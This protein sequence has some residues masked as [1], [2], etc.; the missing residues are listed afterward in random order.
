MKRFLI[1]LFVAAFTIYAIGTLFMLGRY[2]FNTTLNGKDVSLKTPQAVAEGLMTGVQA[3]TLTFELP[4][5]Q[6]KS[7]TFRELGVFSPEAVAEANR[8]L[9][10]WAWPLSLFEKTEYVYEETLKY[11]ERLFNQTIENLAFVK[12]GTVAPT[13]AHVED[14]G[15]GEFV[16]VK[17]KLGNQINV[18]ALKNAVLDALRS[19]DTS[20]DVYE[21]GCYQEAAVKA[22]G[23]DLEALKAEAQKRHDLYEEEQARIR[24]EEAERQRVE[25]LAQDREDFRSMKITLDF[26]ANT[27][28]TL[29]PTELDMMSKVENNK[30]VVDEQAVW[31]YVQDLARIYDTHGKSRV[32][33]T[34][35]GSSVM[36][37]PVNDGKCTLDGWEMNQSEA[38]TMLVSALNARGTQ[39]VVIP[40]KRMGVAHGSVNDFGSTYLEV[41]VDNQHAWCYVDGN[42]IGEGDTVTGKESDPSLRT[43]RGVWKMTDL[44]T[45]HTMTGSYGS[46]FVHYFIRVTE[47]GVGL[48]DAS[49]R[50]VFGGDVYLRDGS[51]GCI[52]MP[53]EP[54]SIIFKALK[55]LQEENR[56]VPII[57]W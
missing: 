13:N 37:S 27:K 3:R 41:S 48:H 36:V 12:Y 47:D 14:R 44:Y 34:S 25:A 45:E 54:V 31:R 28:M 24:A 21:K 23:K 40:W 32:F 53:Y 6:T 26:S 38:Y 43:P 9:Q 55:Q 42:L 35:T 49:W 5:N 29:L 51:H 46:A 15:L 11:N 52:N 16:V 10:P 17:E 30:V 7:V 22:E 39:R 56:T 33:Y 8:E 20:I 4:N 18:R 19:G 1:W 57:I 50:K 2:P